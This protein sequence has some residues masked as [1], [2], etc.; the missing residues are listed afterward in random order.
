[1]K[2]PYDIYIGRWNPKVKINSKWANPFKIGPDGNRQ[3][4]LIKYRF[5]LVHNK[6]LMMS[7]HELRGKVLGCWCDPLDCHGHILA[8]FA[9]NLTHL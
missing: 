2:E 3:Q 4:V 5:W 7:L 6:E 9:D 8:E 1:M